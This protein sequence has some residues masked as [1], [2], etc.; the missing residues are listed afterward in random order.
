[1]MAVL[2][3]LVF[4]APRLERDGRPIELNL[5]KALA[6]LIYLAVSGKPH[7]RDALATLLWPESDGRE[8]RARLRHT[9]HR[10]NETIGDQILDSRPEAICLR[11][12][13]E[14]WLDCAAFRQHVAAGLPA[15]TSPLDPQRLAEMQAALELYADDFLAGFTLPDSPSFDEWQF[16]QRESLRQ[17]Y[18]QVLEQL[19]QAYRARQAWHE[20]IMYARRWLALDGLHEP[21][22]RALMRLYAWAG[23]QATALRQYQECARLLNA[24]LSAAPEE[25]TTALYEAIRTR[26][27]APPEAA[28]R[29]PGPAPEPSETEPYKR[30]VPEER[31]AAGGQ[32]EV[33][34]G[35]DQ[36][37]GRMVAIKW[38]KTELAD[39]HP[40]LVARFVREGAA[41]RRLNHPNIVGIL[42]TFEHAGCYAIVMEYVPGGSLRALLDTARQLGLEQVLAIGLDLADAL[43]RAH[44]HGIV[45]RDLKP[46]NVLLAS[47]GT[48]RLSDFGLARLVWDDVR[49]TQSGTLFGSPAYMSPEAVRGEELDARSDVWSLGVLLYELLAGR[50]PFE[51]VQITPVLAAIQ[52]DPVPD[53]RGF[54]PDAP[55]ALVELLGRMLHK[56]RTQRLPSMRQVAAALE[57]IRDGR[58]AEGR[59]PEQR[60]QTRADL[61]PGAVADT[62]SSAGQ[63][64]SHPPTGAESTA[65]VARTPL[66]A[67]PEAPPPV[68]LGSLGNALPQGIRYA[69][70]LGTTLVGR[71]RESAEIAALLRRDDVRLVTL[72]GP[73]GVGKTRLALAVAE[74]LQAA[75]ADGAIFVGLQAL[76]DATLVLPTIAQALEVVEQ[77]GQRLLTS[78]Q[79][80][81]QDRQVLL[82]LDNFEQVLTA[83]VQV[84]ELLG[85]PTLK[86]LITSRA[87]L[88]LQAEHV[89]SVDPLAVPRPP[90]PPLDELSQYEAVQ[91]FIARAQAVKADFQV[92][93]ANARAV[94]EICAHLDGLPLAIELA[95][96]RVRVL[97][98]EVLLQRLGSRLKVL[99]GGARDLPERQ[100]TLRATIDWSYHLLEPNEQTLFGRLAVFV[101]G[102]TLE[103]AEAI[104][105]A[106]HVL[107]DVLDG[108]QSL[109]E[110][111]LVQ[112]D[113]RPGSEPRFSMLETIREYALERLGVSAETETVRR[114]HTQYFLAL[115]E[116]AERELE[117]AQSATWLTRLEA[118]HD[119]LRAALQW[120][121]ERAETAIALR[122]VGVLWRFW[123]IH[124]HLSEGRTWLGRVLD[125]GSTSS[126]EPE[127]WARGLSG[128]GTLAWVQADYTQAARYH[129]QALT[130]YRELKDKK[131][132]ATALNN[133]AAQLAS[134]GD[135]V[136]AHTLFT[137]SLELYRELGDQLGIIYALANLAVVALHHGDYPGSQALSEE[138]L[139]LSQASRHAWGTANTF[140]N[141]GLAVFQQGDHKRATELFKQGLRLFQE[142]GDIVGMTECLEGLALRHAEVEPARFVQLFAMADRQRSSISAPLPPYLRA[143]YRRYLEAAQS[144]M[145]DGAWTARWAEGSAMTLEQAIAYALEEY[146]PPDAM[147][148]AT[149]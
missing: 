77:G 70:A 57:A 12:N 103:A 144:Q 58:A 1:M 141:L 138:A 92:T 81:L 33:F 130:L 143:A 116:Q 16:F 101:G 121:L 115:A 112:Q 52:A 78:V 139:A 90:P 65:L 73:G 8:G 106:E 89:I 146:L 36:L 99:T 76:S 145:S 21:A 50:R 109:I 148:S 95:A 51:G 22:H 69:P 60:G 71:K 117:T 131:G 63:A 9:L 135:S 26:Q 126:G 140:S 104:C 6:L 105:T 19:V 85:V 42:E 25:E 125:T 107:P 79:T 108:L 67:V 72:T 128:A 29:E 113:D 4:G 28:D 3:L 39:R 17:L 41:L 114:R 119:N 7:S 64:A 137:E 102:W 34:R 30:Y 82:L 147:T 136:G 123:Q 96:A 129:E 14:L 24:E 62:P 88:R 100:Q 98:P 5:R 23:Q 83:G 35:R 43:S 111:S 142:L 15:P 118:E 32:G 59:L 133:L 84:A 66:P 27:L 20:A 53:V 37:T 54:R 93:N 134:Q 10:L 132:N 87:A 91:L 13:A 44:H 56:E 68:S 94:A 74:A 46:E 48:P 75:F 11:P 97:A 49:L 61:A 40:E 47:D 80:A 31:L 110:K 86:M 124:G 149:G 2:K 55:L 38:L 18:G 120:T 45:H 127:Q 122:L